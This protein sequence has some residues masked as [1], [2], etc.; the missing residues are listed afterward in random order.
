MLDPFCGTGGL[1][2][3]A[4]F[5]GATVIGSDIDARVLHGLGVG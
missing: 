4:S 5:F 1:L 3:P 2:I